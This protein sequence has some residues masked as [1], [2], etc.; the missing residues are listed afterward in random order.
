MAVSPATGNPQVDSVTTER[1]ASLHGEALESAIM[2]EAAEESK[3]TASK[4]KEL[5][6]C[7]KSA[8]VSGCTDIVRATDGYF[9]TAK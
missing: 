8:V 5:L 9:P 2:Q 6:C 3:T 1:C 4:M 7:C